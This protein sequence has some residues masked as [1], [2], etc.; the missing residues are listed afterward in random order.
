M[1]VTANAAV[2]SFGGQAAKGT[3][4]TVW[5]R[6]KA[7]NIDL[8]VTDD[9]REG[10]MEIGGI[11]TPTFPYKAGPMVG[12]GAILQPRLEDTFG[13]LLYG[14]LGKCTS[15]PD[16]GNTDVI[17]HVF[18]FNTDPAFVPWMSFR[19][20][21]PRRD[22]TA[23]TDL[24]EVYKDCKILTLTNSFP[25]EG[26]ITTRL[27][28]RGREFELDH[29]PTAWTYD[30]SYEDWES[31][32]VA[33]ATGGFLKIGGV[34]KTIT[35]AN[36]SFTNVAA[37]PGQEKNYGDPF[38]EDIT[39]LNRRLVF[40]L[41]AKWRD[42]DLYALLKSGAVDGTTWSSAP[43]VS[44]F[45]IK[46]VSSVNMPGETEPYSLI[47]DASDV[48]LNEVGGITL[49]A[50]QMIVQRFVGTALDNGGSYCQF[51]LRNKAAGY[52]WPT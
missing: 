16:Y 7:L 48:M 43:T 28:V 44:A 40:D 34:E 24:G 5:M 10:P 1:G 33:C 45:Q 21:V 39:V 2:L 37:D 8:A 17:D 51:T 19:K 31:I 27:D 3:L 11:P 14:A 32:P 29:D 20:A 52:V 47:V 49:A 4:A 38:M 41:V 15:T 6:H 12:G 36:V 22:A 25:N 13:W 50:N 9:I 35:S 46:T 26:P 23:D 42:P 30:N 18:E